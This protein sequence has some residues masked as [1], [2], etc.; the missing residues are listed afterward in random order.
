M[1]PTIVQNINKEIYRRFPELTGRRPRVQAIKQGQANGNGGAT[2][3]E[4]RHLL[5]Y[6]SR[7][8]TSTGKQMPFIVRVTVNAQG[9]ILKVSSSR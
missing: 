4:A 9:K 8:S 6:S 2:P 5:V 1:D 3:A 7:A